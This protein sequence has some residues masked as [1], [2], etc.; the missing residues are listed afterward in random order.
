MTDFTPKIKKTETKPV[1]R[2]VLNRLPGF[3]QE[4]RDIERFFKGVANHFFEPAEIEEISGFIGRRGTVFNSNDYYIPETT[5]SR[6]NY[7]LE[8]VMVSRD[9]E[10]TINFFKFYEDLVDHLRVQGSLTENHSRLFE[11]EY[12]SWCPPISPDMLINFSNYY[13]LAGGP[14]VIEVT[15]QTNVVLD[16]IGKS[17]ADLPDGTPLQ[18][19]M[20]IVFR[21]DSNTEFNN[22]NFL[23][24][25]V[26]RD[27][28]LLDDSEFNDAA[29][30]VPDY[31]VIERG[32]RD[33]NPWSIGNRWF[34]RNQIEDVNFADYT[35]VQARRP[36]I[37]FESDIQL[38]DMGRK[39]RLPV[40]L[41]F[42]GPLSDIQRETSATVDGILV[43][44]GMRILVTGEP[45]EGQNNAVYRVTGRNDT[46]VY[47]LVKEFDG[48][49]LDGS[50]VD[51]EVIRVL[52]GTLNAGKRFYWDG[53]SW[54]E[55]QTKSGI[56]TYPLFELYDSD[57]TVLDDA[58]VYPGSTFN[59]SRIFGFFEDPDLT[60]DQVLGL[61]ISFN[62]FGEIVYENFIETDSF[63]YSLDAQTIEISGLKFFRLN[64]TTSATDEYSSD[65]R[66]PG[67]L[68]RQP[69]VDSWRLKQ[70]ET[71]DGEIEYP[72]SFVIG[73]V[74]EQEQERK[75]QTFRLFFN[76]R[77]LEEGVDYSRSENR[78]E[79]SLSLE[80]DDGDL[81]EARSFDRDRRTKPESGYYRVPA[82]LQA[83]PLNSGVT[84]ISYNDLFEHFVSI[85]E[86]QPDITGNPYGINN[87][88]STV[89][90]LANGTEILQHSASLLRLMLLTRDKELNIRNAIRYVSLEYQKWYSRFESVLAEWVQ[91]GEI[92][93]FASDDEIID[94]II[95][96]IDLGKNSEFPF[97]N[98]GMIAGFAPST[99]AYLGFGPAFEP[100]EFI[101]DTITDRTIKWRRNHDGSLTR[102]VGGR[103]DEVMLALENKFY[104]NIPEKFKENSLLFSHFDVAP[105]KFRESAYSKEEWDR[106]MR[107]LFENWAYQNGIDHKPNTTFDSTDPF[108]YNYRNS[109][110]RDGE[111]LPGHW[112]GI[113]RHYFDTDRPHS[114]PWEMLGFGSK[115][116]WWVDV[117][118]DA[119]YTRENLPMWRDLA[120]GRIADPNDTRVDPRFIRENLLTVIPV[121]AAGDLLDP[122]QAGI[123]TD[124]PVTAYAEENW[125]FGDVSPVEWLWRTSNLYP[126]ALAATTYLARPAE[127]TEK[128]WNTGDTSRFFRDQ[129]QTQVL[130]N[131][132]RR[133]KRYS[134][135]SFHSSDNR[136][137]GSQQWISD[138]WLSQGLS[139][140]DLGT[141]INQLG[142]QLGYRAGSFINRDGFRVTADNFGLVPEENMN[143]V[144]NKS[145]SRKEP[146]Y[147]GLIVR[148]DGAQYRIR[149]FDPLYP[150]VRYLSPDLSGQRS[151]F[152]VGRASGS[153]Y[154]AFSDKI[155]EYEYDDTVATIQDAINIITGHGAFLEKQ[156]W[157][158]DEYLE[159]TSEIND[160]KLMAREF[161]KWASSDLSEDDVLF[162]SPF[163]ASAKFESDFGLVDLV[164]QFT[165]GSWTALDNEAIPMKTDS[166]TV[167]RLDNRIEI[168][169]DRP[170]SLALLRLTV[171][172]YDHAI[173]FDN[174]TSFGNLLYKPEINLRQKRLR[175]LGTRAKFWIGR[176]DAP[177]YLITDNSLVANFDTRAENIRKFYDPYG[178]GASSAALQHARHLVGY[179]KQQHMQDMLLD[180]RS[181]F[182]FFRGFL[183][184][185]GTSASFDRLLRSSF[186]RNEQ[187][188]FQIFEEWAFKVGEYGARDVQTSLEFKLLQSEIKADP[189]TV[190]FTTNPNVTDDKTDAIIT[191]PLSDSRWV[192]TA[193][194]D[195]SNRFY[196]RNFRNVLGK[197]L[198]T[199]GWSQ[200]G[201]ND[202]LVASETE[203]SGLWENRGPIT[204]GQTAWIVKDQKG[205]W[206][207][208]RF[209]KAGDLTAILPGATAEDPT[210][211]TVYQPHGLLAGDLVIISEE[212]GTEPELK[213]THSVLEVLDSNTFTIETGITTGYS[214]QAVGSSTEQSPTTLYDHALTVNGQSVNF[215]TSNPNDFSSDPSPATVE[216]GGLDLTVDGNT[217]TFIGNIQTGIITNPVIRSSDIT[218]S[219]R[220]NGFPVT[221]DHTNIEGSQINPVVTVDGTSG[222]YINGTDVVWT[223]SGD[224]DAIINDINSAGISRIFADKTGVGS[225]RL[226]IWN[227]ADQKINLRTIGNVEDALEKLGFAFNS[228]VT[229]T[230]ASPTVTVD[231]ANGLNINGTPVIFT[232]AGDAAAV[233]ND[234]NTAAIANISATVTGGA[235]Q[236]DHA[237]SG[238]IFIYDLDA[239]EDAV[240]IIGFTRTQS[241]KSAADYV[242]DINSQVDT[243]FVEASVASGKI[244]LEVKSG[245]ELE[246]EDLTGTPSADFGFQRFY[247][248]RTV[249]QVVA[250]MVVSGIAAT[251]EA[252]TSISFS[253]PSNSIVA[254]SGTARE[255]LGLEAE[256]RAIVSYS[257]II[258]QLD[259]LVVTDV[260]FSHSNGF[261][262]FTSL[263]GGDLTLSGTALNSLGFEASY[264]GGGL[265]VDLNRWI[266]VRRNSV[267]AVGSSAPL[268]G[269]NSGDK[270]FVDPDTETNLGLPE[271]GTRRWSVYEYNGA[272]WDQ[273]RYQKDRIDTPMI[274]SVFL[275]DGVSGR[276]VSQV[277]TWDP[278]KRVIPGIATSE[279]FYMLEVD[280][281]DYNSGN[282]TRVI[283]DPDD[284]W[285]I[286]QTGRLWW[287]ISA[288]RYLDYEQGSLAYRR[289]YWGR[290]LPGSSI[291]LYE[292]T[293]SPV[294]PSEWDEY[295][296]TQSENAASDYLPSGTV[297]DAE[298]PAW[299]EKIEYDRA[300]QQNRKFYYFWV[301]NPI[302]RPNKKFRSRSAFDVSKIIDSPKNSGV[303]FFSP[304]ETV[305]SNGIDTSSFICGNFQNLITDEDTVIQIN[306]R[307]NSE[308]DR[309]VHKEWVLLREN[310]DDV[311]EPTLWAK[312]RDSLIGEDATGLSIPDLNLNESRRY[313]I[314]IR[315]R[316]SMFK[317]RENARKTFVNAANRILIA[318]NIVDNRAE[319]E[320]TFLAKDPEPTNFDF[321]VNTRSERDALSDNPLFESGMTVLVLEDEAD[322][323]KWTHWSWD[324]S[325]FTLLEKESYDASNFWSYADWYEASVDQNNPPKKVYADLTK[326]DQNAFTDGEI[327]E[328]LDQGEGRWVWTK[329]NDTGA[330]SWWNTVAIEAGTVQIN[331]NLYSFDLADNDLETE[332]K[333]VIGLFVDFFDS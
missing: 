63:S 275:F 42:D 78:V 105:G 294:P 272:T 269:W 44:D 224:L 83:N 189:Q 240:E 43:E 168:E 298:D 141:A 288:V 226:R 90:N 270:A 60:P 11:S 59:G 97:S 10:D 241:G 307:K 194:A 236:I 183:R 256:Y 53:S 178:F 213:G 254:V 111:S 104:S 140:S 204:E 62:S 233:V 300:S 197:D 316:Q 153:I 66:N 152:S 3:L 65:W 327:V 203:F 303:P 276:T 210:T 326:R 221:F 18:S 12:W 229:G 278:V 36:I 128:T 27:I 85:I 162:L 17:Q 119:P 5:E 332:T 261:M 106:I 271:N 161:I 250:E 99:P 147:S 315:P 94:A 244:Q 207:I 196:L 255:K 193:N 50:P 6:Q 234:I 262:T 331:G 265:G 212:T 142:A 312:M 302:Y 242:G 109:I 110:D 48:E 180:D 92:D 57:G 8:P 40:D 89:R 323:N 30:S 216:L 258:S 293:R 185:K 175:V 249:A 237:T 285:G 9:A 274:E 171:I 281:A 320:S 21:N 225:N 113:Y 123:V 157:I 121:S 292:W 47:V 150:T 253:Y 131:E 263:D 146:V 167:S 135:E 156:G 127:W 117:Y 107:P 310:S 324:G 149:G 126:F 220:L 202:F 15:D 26:G 191:I 222:L 133:R 13:W 215:T 136:N 29:D 137:I 114:H 55:G 86:N 295:V 23:V 291:N 188:D 251:E 313:G 252:D 247:A 70:Q 228:Q 170:E 69:V 297:K 232:G 190:T 223:G 314:Q 72:R 100:G 80:I 217:V 91:T 248:A 138:Y 230:N 79:L 163:S 268:L 56:N 309:N 219:F 283:H 201:E 4:H 243:S 266:S 322:K 260:E 282:S 98:T 200:L 132:L 125:R 115:P 96:E 143:F 116:G 28:R 289:K 2:N 318:E 24:V 52:G 264:A 333:I 84:I 174:E 93:N 51:D 134:E 329:F 273:L 246:I 145:A 67:W 118:G 280:P 286:E 164:S 296:E 31:I 321:R 101:D 88:N 305:H 35:A 82:N 54:V 1:P 206:D 37:Q 151:N 87:F 330:G 129:V 205:D 214:T 68:S 49:S 16:I 181:Q 259:A 39:A 122:I 328:V 311:V 165:N 130:D 317:D 64:G 284:S 154:S 76:N 160:W 22:V 199:G 267:A 19:G 71:S 159:S 20:R 38:R 103:Q 144:L 73:Q 14:P 45:T 102:V 277:S 301:L 139:Q 299:V 304:V 46:G 235:V 108:T 192:R 33:Q 177:G 81:L 61:N 287:D 176:F 257:E 308:D 148:W 306:F 227:L 211:L 155:N 25:N 95:A 41:V 74:P 58:G 124:P 186:V 182:N 198:P 34:H 77:L 112:R 209:S 187:E 231:A 32:A 279:I 239:A 245:G 120:A 179:Q 208:R 325:E 172:E 75:Y 173:I 7:Q 290:K 319:W 158:F 195:F 166:F 238:D 184:E 169:H 218:T